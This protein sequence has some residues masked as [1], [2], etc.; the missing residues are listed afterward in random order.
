MSLSGFPSDPAKA[1]RRKFLIIFLSAISLMLLATVISADQS[2]PPDRNIFPANLG[3]FHQVGRITVTDK[4]SLRQS[5]KVTPDA[6]RDVQQVFVAETG[7]ESSNG[8]KLLVSVSRFENDSAAYSRFTLLR[9]NGWGDIE[10]VP[11]VGAA[12][13][14]RGSALLFLKGATLVTV[15][16]ESKSGNGDNQVIE[17]ARLF[18]STVDA[19]EGEIPVLVKHLP[20]W[21]A[22][23]H[24][25]TYFVNQSSLLN[26]IPNQ[27][28][29]KEL[30]FDGGTEAVVANYDRSQLVIVEFTTP[31]FSIENDQRIWTK[32][33]ELKSQNQPT[34]IAY[35]RVGNYSVFVFNAPDEKTA[36]ALVD[37]VRYEQIVQWLGDDPH[38]AER[39]TRYFRHTTSGVLIAVVKSSGL[40]LILCAAI[41]TLFGAMLFRHRRARQAA[42]YSDA[43]GST[44]L[45]LDELTDVSKSQ[46]LLGPG[47]QPEAD[48]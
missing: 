7:Y 29:L 11:R 22:A 37:Q 36:N 39:L 33:S 13:L 1:S 17:L 46:R 4:E 12:M 43:G 45:N 18:A 14:L 32:I 41:G 10:Q 24:D 25:A 38:M 34:P 31:Q 42:F 30:N 27:P 16:P 3:S 28:I 20:N 19:G 21:E 6:P 48:S 5:L 2:T 9:K 35:R 44:R 23:E 15:Q 26:A 8:D 40:S 47:E